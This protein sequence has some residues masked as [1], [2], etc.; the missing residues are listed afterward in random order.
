VGQDNIGPT[1]REFPALLR[2]GKSNAPT[3]DPETALVMP[4]FDAEEDDSA[5][6]DLRPRWELTSSPYDAENPETAGVPGHQ[7]VPR[8]DDDRCAGEEP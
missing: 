6:D 5:Q 7:V 1:T 4:E 8:R 3:V 2:A